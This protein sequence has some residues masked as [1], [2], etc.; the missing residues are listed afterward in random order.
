[1]SIFT[2][3][4]KRFTAITVTALSRY[5]IFILKKSGGVDI[6]EVLN[7]GGKDRYKGGLEGRTQQA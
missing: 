1:M 7:R 2:K 3:P 6:K 5:F 4:E